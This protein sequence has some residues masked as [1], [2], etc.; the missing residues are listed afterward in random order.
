MEFISKPF[1]YLL[2]SILLPTVLH[3]P[4]CLSTKP[5]KGSWVL[6]RSLEQARWGVGWGVGLRHH[7]DDFIP[8]LDA[9]A[10]RGLGEIKGRDE[11]RE[12][13]DMSLSSPIHPAGER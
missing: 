1:L 11:S 8:E 4:P 12:V 7:S 6:V 2:F 5:V 13:V 10:W 3:A 9:R